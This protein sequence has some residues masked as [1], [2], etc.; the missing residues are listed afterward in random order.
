MLKKENG[1]IA[2]DSSTER[3]A[4]QAQ[5]VPTEEAVEEV[6]EVLH[7]KQILDFI[8]N[9]RLLWNNLKTSIKNLFLERLIVQKQILKI[10]DEKNCGTLPEIL[11]QL[12]KVNANSDFVKTVRLKLKDFRANNLAQIPHF[13]EHLKT[14]LKEVFK[15]WF[16][17]KFGNLEGRA[18]E[19]PPARV[20][21][22][23]Q[24]LGESP[25]LKRRPSIFEANNSNQETARPPNQ[26]GR[27]EKIDDLNDFF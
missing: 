22:G 18:V 1:T 21:L 9:P 25:T 24:Q 3:A 10:Y 20:N 5:P 11:D 6:Q 8:D 12:T 2:L 19:Q 15:F 23:V 27:L 16:L 26:R 14:I 7:D 13:K 4:R 17:Q